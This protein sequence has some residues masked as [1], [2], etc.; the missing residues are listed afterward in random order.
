MNILIS[1]Q[2]MSGCL[3]SPKM[4]PVPKNPALR[5]FLGKYLQIQDDDFPSP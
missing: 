2:S 3:P 4:G 5:F 1:E